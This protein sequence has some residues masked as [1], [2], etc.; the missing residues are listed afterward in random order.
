MKTSRPVQSI[1]KIC[2]VA[3]VLLPFTISGNKLSA[4]TYYWD[5]NG[6]NASSGAAE[7]TWDSGT[8][9]LWTTDSTGQSTPAIATTATNDTVIFSAGTNGTAGTV[10]VSGTQFAQYLVINQSGLTF[11]GGQI[12]SSSAL[13]TATI[14]ASATINSNF[15]G[16]LTFS[17]SNQ[18][19]TLSGGGLLSGNGSYV[20]NAAT[21]AIAATSAVN[22]AS[23]A[24]TNNAT[25]RFNIGNITNPGSTGLT[26]GNGVTLASGGVYVWIGYGADGVVTLDG[27]NWT[28]SLGLIIGRANNGLLTVKSGTLT[29]TGNAINNGITVGNDGGGKLDVQGGVITTNYLNI[30]CIPTAGSSRSGIMLVSGGTTNINTLTFGNGYSGA[31]TAGSGTLAIS[32]GLV[33]IGAGGIVNGVSTSGTYKYSIVLSGG[34]L[35]SYNNANWNSSLNMTLAT[36]TK[37]NVTFDGGSHSITLSGVLSGT[38][39]LNVGGGT[40][41][42]SGANT[43]TGNTLIT[44]QLQLTNGAQLTFKIGANG[45][46]TYLGGSGLLVTNGGFLFDLTG[47]SANGG[48]Q[49][50]IVQSTLQTQYGANFWIGDTVGGQWSDDSGIWTSASGTYQFDQSQGILSV[51]PEPSSV[52]LLLGGGTLLLALAGPRRRA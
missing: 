7:G 45:N 2:F 12:G 8:T 34:T 35:G 3:L 11:Q 6:I 19:V 33:N 27:G 9:A 16:S 42:L 14:G 25:T 18:T 30:G 39:G 51:I 20:F 40:L 50:I 1:T 31:S 13:V 23:G 37:G 4:A 49:W 47:A 17:A 24:Y 10:T 32:D 22:L 21:T 29:N 28:H 38:G 48:D 15:N 52:V 41:L 46:N 26:I 44:A 43:Y 5:T 36:G